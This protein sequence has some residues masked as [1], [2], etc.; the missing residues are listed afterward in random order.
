M[1]KIQLDEEAYQIVAPDGTE[2]DPTQYG[3]PATLEYGGELYAAVVPDQDDEYEDLGLRV[4]CLR[5]VETE[6]EE[7]ELELEEDP[8]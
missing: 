1:W 2:S 8:G 4:F 6:V 7:V 5:P 3:E